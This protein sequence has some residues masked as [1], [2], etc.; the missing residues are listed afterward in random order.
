MLVK[1]SIIGPSYRTQICSEQ[2]ATLFPC[3]H[4]ALYYYRCS[5]YI[6]ISA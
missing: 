6:F 1:S 2:F 3:I 4:T 5:D